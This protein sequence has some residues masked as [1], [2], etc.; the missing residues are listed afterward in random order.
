MKFGDSTDPRSAVIYTGRLS[1]CFHNYK[2]P[3]CLTKLVFAREF[4]SQ[5][6][7]ESIC[8]TNQNRVVRE[9]ERILLLSLLLKDKFPWRSFPDTIII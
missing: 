6:I 7:S 3:I 4:H 9:I 1:V 5:S 2:F 8:K